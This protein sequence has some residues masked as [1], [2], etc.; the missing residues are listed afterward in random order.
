[1]SRSGYVDWDD[2][3]DD[4]PELIAGRWRGQVASATRG[5]RGQAFFRDLIAALDAMPTKVLIT[6]DLYRGQYVC[7][8]GAVGQ[9]R[10]TDMRG[11]DPED[12]AKVA[13]RLDIA[14]PLVR[15]VVYENDEDG[16]NWKEQRRETPAERWKRMRAWAVSQL[17]EGD[18]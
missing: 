8:I 18:K 16:W 15:E 1:M 11:L 3:N 17:N 7:A 13:G 10:K 5:K 12:T 4:Y 14:D 6:D 2:Y 9:Y